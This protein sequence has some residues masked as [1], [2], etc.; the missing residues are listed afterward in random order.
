MRST[1]RRGLLGTATGLAATGLA[2]IGLAAI[3][4]AGGAY[5][6]ALEPGFRM[7]VRRHALSVS[8][9]CTRPPLTICVLTDFHAGEFWMPLERVGR[10]VAAANALRLD[11]HVIL[12]DLRSSH[13]RDP[14]S[15]PLG[16]TTAEAVTPS[17][18]CAPRWAASQ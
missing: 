13:S 9:W 6:F 2:A 8:G 15:T 16:A 12:G 11:L 4:A 1:T 14:G 10:V 3:G 18:T 7:V 17:R 5:G